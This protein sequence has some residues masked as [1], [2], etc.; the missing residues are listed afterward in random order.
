MYPVLV[1]FFPFFF[2]FFFFF[3]FSNLTFSVSGFNSSYFNPFFIIE[4]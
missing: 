4:F 3:H 1:K 2:F